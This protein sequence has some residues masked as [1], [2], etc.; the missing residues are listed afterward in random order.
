VTLFELQQRSYE[1]AG[2][3]VRG[4]WPPEQA[5]TEDEL[6][7]Y[8]DR[9]RFCVLAT[10]TPSGAPQARPVAFVRLDGTLWFAT[11]A[12]ARLRNVRADPRVSV[13]I[14]EGDREEHV[15]VLLEG[16]V[17]V[18]EDEANRERVVAA[19]REQQGGTLDWAAAFLELRPERVFSYGPR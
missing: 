17:E 14:P 10:T 8:L 12:G 6:E 2:R 7:A 19:W 4:S 15:M 5:M 18:H 1:R 11:V 3:A 16:M 9:R 13:V